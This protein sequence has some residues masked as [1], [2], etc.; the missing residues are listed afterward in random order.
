MFH[1]PDWECFIVGL[2]KACAVYSG[3]R[4][5]K[6]QGAGICYSNPAVQILGNPAEYPGNFFLRASVGAEGAED[7]LKEGCTG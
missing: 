5:R 1:C 7:G 2:T 4:L 3:S 6:G